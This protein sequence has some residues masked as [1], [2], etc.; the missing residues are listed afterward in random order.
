MNRLQ[1]WRN[2]LHDCREAV[3]SYSPWLVSGRL[4][5][6]AGLVMEA[7]GLKLAVG[8]G[9][10]VSLPGSHKVDA[11]VVG[12]SGDKLFLMPSTDVYGLVPGAK[13]IPSEIGSHYP[14]RLGGEYFPKR[15]A[16]DRIKQVAEEFWMVRAG[17]WIAL[18]NCN[19]SSACLCKAAP[20]TPWIVPR[21]AK[22]WMLVC[23]Q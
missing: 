1:T 6:V 3:A 5:R 19:W 13:V 15:R 10:I 17:H 4:T 23:V 8:S 11:E 22:C 16:E 20:I 12:F 2:Y 9:C 18:G 7:V 14:P 21:F